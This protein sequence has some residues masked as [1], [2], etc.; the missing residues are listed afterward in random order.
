MHGPEL[1]GW[2]WRAGAGG[3]ALEFATPV[4]NLAHP[5]AVPV[6]FTLPGH[7]GK[8]RAGPDLG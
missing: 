6:S 4:R 3:L 2:R 7:G 8:R 5:G 1:E